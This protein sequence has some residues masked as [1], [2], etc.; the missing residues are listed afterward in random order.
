MRACRRA[1]PGLTGTPS[2]IVIESNSIMVAEST[3]REV[4]RLHEPQVYVIEEDRR[5]NR[6]ARGGEDEIRAGTRTSNAT[7][8]W[9]MNALFELLSLSAL[10]MHASFVGAHGDQ[11]GTPRDHV[12]A[13]LRN[14]RVERLSPKRPSPYAKVTL[15]YSGRHPNGG[16]ARDDYVMA[17]GF[18]LLIWPVILQ[19]PRFKGLIPRQLSQR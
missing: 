5:K 16:R 19:S 7:K 9:Q 6:G 13:E 1:L 3:K 11:P 8:E 18:I 14:M 2:F 4:Q 15:R 17:L 10:R 12:I